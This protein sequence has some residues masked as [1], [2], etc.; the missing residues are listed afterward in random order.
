MKIKA[1][2]DKEFNQI[3]GWNIPIDM[4]WEE[5]VKFRKSLGLECTPRRA[6]FLEEKEDDKDEDTIA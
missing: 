2:L 5:F 6:I 4:T 1:G 3:N